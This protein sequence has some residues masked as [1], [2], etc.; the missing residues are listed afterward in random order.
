MAKFSGKTVLDSNVWVA[1][2][3]AQDPQHQAAADIFESLDLSKVYIH[4]FIIL[5]IVSVLRI[6]AN[7]KVAAKA[8]ELLEQLELKIIDADFAKQEVYNLTKTA[9]YPK[10]SFVDMFLLVLSKKYKIVTFDKALAR[11]LTAYK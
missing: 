5:E 10:L 9:K 11:A 7:A 8:L 6:R 2:F 1:Y 4:D 3:L